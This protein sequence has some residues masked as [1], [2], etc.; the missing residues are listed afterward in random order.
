M[1]FTKRY[2][3]RKFNQKYNKIDRTVA[4]FL[5]IPQINQKGYDNYYF[6]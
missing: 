6:L 5:S 2:K 1:K 3:Q 4:G